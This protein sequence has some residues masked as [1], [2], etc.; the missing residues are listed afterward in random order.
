MHQRDKIFRLV[1]VIN[2]YIS[3]GV[4]PSMQV[5]AIPGAGYDANIFLAS[6]ER[7]VLVDAGTGYNSE[8][9][10][11]KI[12]EN[13]ALE[14]VDVIVLTHEHFDHC[15]AVAGL[16]ERCDAEVYMHEN[17]AS[18]VER[19]E[20]WS[21]GWFGTSQEPTGVDRRLRDGDMIPLGGTSLRVIHT[22]GHSPGGIC[23]YEAA[24]KSLFSGDLIFANGGVGRTDFRGGDPAMLA[25]SIH[26]LDMPVTNLYPGHGPYVEGVGQRHVDMAARAVQGWLD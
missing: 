21:A 5:S 20:D 15:G 19:G 7:H 6:N 2:P 12:Q 8:Y 24:S 18:V 16:R 3:W 14:N 4:Y 26:A 22:P 25:R 23:L 13:I 17:G 11:R 10:Y 1:V 9:V